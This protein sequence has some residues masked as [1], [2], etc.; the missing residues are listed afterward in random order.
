[1]RLRCRVLRSTTTLSRLRAGHSILSSL[2][3]QAKVARRSFS[4]GG[5]T[6]SLTS[7]G[8]RA[9]W[10]ARAGAPR[11]ARCEQNVCRRMCTPRRFVHVGEPTDVIWPARSLQ[12]RAAEYRQRQCNGELRL[13]AQENCSDQS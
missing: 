10:I 8:W 6:Q 13:E 2:A 4:E 11:M 7:Y 12:E 9:T 1:M 5:P 3:L